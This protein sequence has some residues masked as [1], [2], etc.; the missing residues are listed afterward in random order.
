[1]ITYNINDLFFKSDF[2]FFTFCLSLH[3][4]DHLDSMR[5]EASEDVLVNLKS[6]CLLCARNH[7]VS[8]HPLTLV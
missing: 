5:G 4:F 8:Q 7:M 3:Y 6:A 1:M 2:N